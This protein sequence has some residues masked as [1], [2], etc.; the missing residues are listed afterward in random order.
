MSLD[1]VFNTKLIMLVILIGQLALWFVPV[2]VQSPSDG[3]DTGSQEEDEEI[4]E[5]LK[6]DKDDT[7]KTEIMN[8][9]SDQGAMEQETQGR[10]Y[11]TCIPPRTCQKSKIYI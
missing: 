10:R 8:H 11:Q 4:R 1:S 5:A 3:V 7:L 6:D 9:E 2:I